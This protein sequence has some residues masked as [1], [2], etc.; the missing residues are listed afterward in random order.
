MKKKE[1]TPDINYLDLIPEKNSSLEWYNDYY[2]K[3]VLKVENTGFFNRLAQKVFN[4]PK[5]T[6]VHLDAQGSYI[7]PF[8]DGKKTVMELAQIQK[9]HFGEA[10]EPLYPRIIKYFQIVESYHFIRF[11]NRPEKKK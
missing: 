5:Y 10:A 8:I 3:V 7:W 6:K 9:E 4:K 2:G 1:N 11:I